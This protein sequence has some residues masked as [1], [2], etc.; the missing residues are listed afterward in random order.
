MGSFL[1]IEELHF[2]KMTLSEKLWNGYKQKRLL[3]G[4]TGGG[5][6]CGASIGGGFYTAASSAYT[7]GREQLLEVF[8]SANRAGSILFSSD[9]KEDFEWL[10]TT[11]AQKLID[12]HDYLIIAIF[13]LLRK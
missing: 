9:G 11:P 10:F 8:A 13:C 4:I 7:E 2:G 12:G 6:T 3:T 1:W 5:R